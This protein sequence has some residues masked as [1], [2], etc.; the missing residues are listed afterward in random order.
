MSLLE[1]TTNAL[2]EDRRR[3]RSK[4]SAVL[5]P[6]VEDVFHFSTTRVCD[7][8]SI[9]KRAWSEFH[10]ALKPANNQPRRDILCCTFRNLFVGVRV[11]SKPTL[12]QCQTD[13]IV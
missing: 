7:D 5:D 2:L 4:R 6:I 10:P 1:V 11:K 12:L 9:A 3:K 8:R 13:L